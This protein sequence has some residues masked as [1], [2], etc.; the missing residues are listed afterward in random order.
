MAAGRARPR[1]RDQA[2]RARSQD[3]AGAGVAARGTPAR[4]VTGHHRQRADARRIRRH[5]RVSGRTLRQGQARARTG[6]AGTAAL[7]LL[8]ALR[9]RVGDAA[10]VAEARVQPHGEWSDA[11]FRQTRGQGHLAACA[12][13]VRRPADQA[14]SRLH[15][16]GTREEPLVRRQRI[17]GGRRPVEFSARSSRSAG[18]PRRKQAEI[19]GVSWIAFTRDRPTVERWSEA[20]NT[21]S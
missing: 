9:G 12:R 6:N 19:D 13:D 21:L 4:Q 5:R 2:L 7:H 10:A 8:A 16:G 3:H 20:A 17:L 18:R 11:V 15:G 1:V 14:A